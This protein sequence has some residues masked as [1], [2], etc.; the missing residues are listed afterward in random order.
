MQFKGAEGLYSPERC[1]RLLKSSRAVSD[2]PMRG[3]FDGL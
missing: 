3:S 2:L 1:A